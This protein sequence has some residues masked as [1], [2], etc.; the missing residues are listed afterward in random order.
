MLTLGWSDGNSF[1]G[2]DFALLSS[3]DKKNRYNEINPN[4]DNLKV[5]RKGMCG[6]QRRQEAIT[7]STMHL[8]PIVKKAIKIGIRAKY[9]VMDSW[10]SMLS[11]ISSLRQHIHIICMLGVARPFINR[12]YHSR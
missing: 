4:I 6:Y 9:L 7:K 1:L 8:E 12:Y 3:A 5:T 2:I 10:F 11:V